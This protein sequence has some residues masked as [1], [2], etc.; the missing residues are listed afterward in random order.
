MNSALKFKLRAHYRA[1]R[2][3][4]SSF[5]RMESAGLAAK[6]LMENSIFK[7]SQHIACYLSMAEEFDSSPII[8]AIW[9][10]K[11]KCYLPLVATDNKSLVFVRYEYGDALH[12]NRYSILEPAKI[13]EKISPSLLDMTIIPLVAFDLL[14]HRLGMGGGYYDHTFTVSE[15]TAQPHIIGLA[16]AAQQAE[17]LPFDSW[18]V[19]LDGVITE[20]TFFIFG[21]KS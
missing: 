14:G 18:D 5:Y 13:T 9:Q 11:K 6:H 3:H 21:K 19:L 10:A 8:E 12:R 1:I 15:N 20:K 7:K 2:S 16:Y 17:Q 4:I